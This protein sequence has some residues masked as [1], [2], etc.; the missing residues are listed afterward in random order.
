L[1][2]EARKHLEAAKAALKRL[3]EHLEGVTM[4]RASGQPDARTAR[5]WRILDEVDQLGGALTVEDWRALGLRH[6][7]NPKGLGGF[8]TGAEPSMRSEADMRA[9]TDAGRRWLTMWRSR[10]GPTPPPPTP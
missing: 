9:L 2:S 5:W 10:F 8:F 7:Y 6:G 3:E 1:D 4:E